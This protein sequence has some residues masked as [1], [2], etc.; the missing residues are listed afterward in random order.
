MHGLQTTIWLNTNNREAAAYLNA[1]DPGHANSRRAETELAE[2]VPRFKDL[3]VPDLQPKG[4]VRTEQT[5]SFGPDFIF[6]AHGTEGWLLPI[7]ARGREI[8][9]RMFPAGF[10]RYGL[11]YIL[12]LEAE[13]DDAILQSI[14]ATYA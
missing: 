10:R 11:H 13:R 8:A 2:A 6:Q 9:G 12:D 5:L 7:S 14:L 1:N 3:L 4:S